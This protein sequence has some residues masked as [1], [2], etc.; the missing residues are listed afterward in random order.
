MTAPAREPM[1]IADFLAWS[2]RHEEGHYE[3]VD[4][5]IVPLPRA[6]SEHVAAKGKIWRAIAEALARAGAPCEAY[7][8]GL[9]VAV[10]A[11]NVYEPDILVNCGAPIAT[12]E[13]LAPAPVI[14][15]AV[16][17]PSSDTIGESVRREGY[18]RV[19]S[20]AHYL[21]VDLA[22]RAVTH[23]RRDG[24]SALREETVTEGSI[25]LDPPGLDLALKD[26]F[27]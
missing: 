12:E 8:G 20:V 3:L 21:I 27:A 22:R 4:G 23:C 6:P 7:V 1:T 16:P 11:H 17:A 5:E 24:G 26:I 15:V 14:I 2:E 13:T 19:A 25:R 18:F 9:G 10:D